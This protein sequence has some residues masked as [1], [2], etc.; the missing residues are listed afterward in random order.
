MVH[1]ELERDIFQHTGGM[2]MFDFRRLIDL[3]VQCRGMTEQDGY[4]YRIK[5]KMTDFFPVKRVASCNDQFLG[6]AEGDCSRKLLRR[7]ISSTEHL[8]LFRHHLHLLQLQLLHPVHHLHHLHQLH[9]HHMH[10][11]HHIHQLHIHHLYIIYISFIIYTEV[12]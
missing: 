5:G 11:L 7:F 1:A 3:K 2:Q 10:H 12:L 8:L 9:Q 4:S 6:F